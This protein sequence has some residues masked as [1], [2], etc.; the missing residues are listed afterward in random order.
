MRAHDWCSSNVVAS[1]NGRANLHGIMAIVHRECVSKVVD[2][3]LS[4]QDY[5]RMLL[6]LTKETL[7][8]TDRVF[9]R[10]RCRGSWLGLF[11]PFH[12]H[13]SVPRF[14]GGWQ[15]RRNRCVC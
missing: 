3:T 6:L 12:T 9:K 2:R 10:V 8:Y 13:I 1:V 4:K 14:C 5:R 7:S 15:G 11:D